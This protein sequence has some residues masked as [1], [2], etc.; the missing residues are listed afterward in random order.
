MTLAVGLWIGVVFAQPDGTI[1]WSADAPTLICEAGVYGRMARTV[2]GALVCVHEWHGDIWL[3]R[4]GADGWTLGAQVAAYEH[5]PAAN[6]EIV[7][8]PDG[9]LLCAY[10]ER[11]RDGVHPFAIAITS[12]S[13][14]GHTWTAPR[15]VYRAGARWESGCWEPAMLAT[16]S[17]EIQLFFAN[18]HPYPDTREQEIALCRS[19]DGGATWTPPTAVIFRSGH[20]DGMPVPLALRDDSGT[21]VAIEDD[22]IDGI[23]KPSV[24]FS[25]DPANWSGAPVGGDSP[26]RW[27]ALRDP[28]PASTY[29]GAPYLRQLL[30]GTTILSVQSDEITPGEPR[31]TVYVGDDRARDF[32]DPTQPFD[33]PSRWNALF[34]HA[35]D[36]ITAVSTTEIGGVAGLWAIDGRLRRRAD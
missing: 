28:L 9:R 26:H 16:P 25:P 20:R 32:V 24:V 1:E 6:P 8:A 12:S 19:L 2:S 27:P 3:S 21:V 30:D 13:D 33:G 17:G 7:V 4:L 35:D 10:N 14:D 31:M 22:G 29:A 18:E 15:H 34:V 36:T 23:L 11:P 5:G